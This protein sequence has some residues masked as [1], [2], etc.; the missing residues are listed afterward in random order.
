VIV[1]VLMKPIV[2]QHF[3]G[4]PGSGG[5][6]T[7]LRRI[8][9][10]PLAEKYQFYA[11]HQPGPAGPLNFRLLSCWVTM[12]RN[13]RPDIVH[14]RGLGNEGFHG[15]LAARLASS[16]RV[17]VSIHGTVRDLTSPMTARRRVLIAGAEPATLRMATHIATVCQWASDR[18]YLNNVRHKLVGVV[19]N[20]VSVMPPDAADRQQ[21][22]KE[23]GL[24]H[25]DV[26]LVVV[27]RLTIEK[28]HLVL[29]DALRLLGGLLTRV[30]LLVVG[31]GP[32][33]ALIRSTYSHV[34]NLR[35]NMLGNQRN[36]QRFLNAADVFV[37]PT[38]HENLSNALL[39]GMAAGLPVVATRVGGNVEVLVRG[40]GELVEPSDPYSLAESIARMVSDQELRIATGHAGT[41]I[42]EANFAM[43]DM[44]SGWDG[45]YSRML[46]ESV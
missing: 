35:V 5:P 1:S 29:A 39:E 21:V 43:R 16:P 8:L 3:A 25:D 34:E 26:G 27:G 19:P 38:L 36:V 2:V 41:R 33:S 42:V 44:L 18:S 20:G 10:S 40:G 24:R 14:V 13:V 45:V 46:G 22:R 37:F 4:A 32:D 30:F 15:A 11:M 6:A 23:M 31:D 28:G 7:A 9:D 17:L 12:L